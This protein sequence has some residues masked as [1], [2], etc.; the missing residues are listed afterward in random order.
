MKQEDR[1]TNVNDFIGELGAGVFEAKLSHILSE[2]ALGTI[3]NGKGNKK[4]K[5]TVEFTLQ[6]VGDN[7]QVIISHKLAHSTPTARGKKSEEDVSD[8]PMFVCKGGRLQSTPPQ[9]D[10][11]GQFHLQQVNS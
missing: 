7:D 6:Q 5:V 1:N 8:T 2:C 9:E 3:L 10:M 11:V 4:G